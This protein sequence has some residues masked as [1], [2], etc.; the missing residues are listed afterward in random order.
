MNE[1]WWFTT[2]PLDLS[3]PIDEQIDLGDIL[4]QIQKRNQDTPEQA[5]DRAMRGIGGK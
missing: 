5:Y 4:D 2:K 1:V 3:R